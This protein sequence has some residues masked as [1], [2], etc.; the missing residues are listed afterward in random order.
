L[1][2]NTEDGRERHS[3]DVTDHMFIVQTLIAQTRDLLMK[4]LNRELRKQGLTAVQF[5]V[6]DLVCILGNEATPTEIANRLL[7]QPHTVSS[8]LIRMENDGLLTRTRSQESKRNVIIALTPK[9]LDLLNEVRSLGGSR[10]LES[11]LGEEEM[12]QLIVSLKKIRSYALDKL[13]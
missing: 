9:G 11:C 8:L 6:L 12:R 3:T 1:P 7:R 5:A 2:A 13:H 4:I 10:G